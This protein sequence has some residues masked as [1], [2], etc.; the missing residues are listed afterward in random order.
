MQFDTPLLSD[1]AEKDETWQAR[2]GTRWLLQLQDAQGAD[3]LFDVLQKES[4]NGVGGTGWNMVKN[5]HFKR[6]SLYTHAIFYSEIMGWIGSGIFVSVE[7]DDVNDEGIHESWAGLRFE[8]G[9]EGGF[10]VD[11]RN[12]KQWPGM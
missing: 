9:F 5:K 6:L 10:T 1:F 7:I 2:T 3:G 11:E 8:I 12:P 4:I